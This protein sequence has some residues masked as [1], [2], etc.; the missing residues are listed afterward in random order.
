MRWESQEQIAWRKWTAAS[1][2]EQHPAGREPLPRTGSLLGKAVPTR[3]LPS[4]R[5]L[6]L[7]YLLVA[8]D[9]A[10]IAMMR[11]VQEPS[12]GKLFEVLIEQPILE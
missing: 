2:A 10:H 12:V 4:R 7:A 6:H 5:H 1:P 9:R 3:Q 11:P 8:T